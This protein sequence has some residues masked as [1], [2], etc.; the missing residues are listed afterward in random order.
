MRSHTPIDGS[1]VLGGYNSMTVIVPNYTQKPDYSNRTACWKGIKVSITGVELLD[2]TG[3][4][5]ILASDITGRACIIPQRQ[6]LLEAPVQIRD[7]FE[8][9]TNTKTISA[10][11]GLHWS[12]TPY[13]CQGRIH[14]RHGWLLK[15][16]QFRSYC[17]ATGFGIRLLP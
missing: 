2:R 4:T 6:L 7:K 14:K 13:E 10:S 15:A 3:S 8:N 1:F 17:C 5:S 11:F 12:A 16:D 9:G